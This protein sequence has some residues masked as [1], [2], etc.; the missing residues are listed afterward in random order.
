M[1]IEEI[2]IPTTRQK[3]FIEYLTLKKPVLDAILTKINK[4]KTCLSEI[5]LKIYAQ[6]LYYNDINKN[7]PEKEKWN[8][9]FGKY[10]KEIIYNSLNL[11]EHQL[12]NYFSMLRKMRILNGRTIN[13]P[14][15]V[16]SNETQL[17]SFKFKING[18]EEQVDR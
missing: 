3:F 8:I 1:A 16:Y 12:N 15:I 18:H 13:K 7:L 14:F 11:K 5:P 10:T 6:L 2:T 4:R 17:L 9:V